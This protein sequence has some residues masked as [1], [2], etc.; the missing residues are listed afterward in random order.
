MTARQ[1]SAFVGQITFQDLSVPKAR[2]SSS[3][4]RVSSGRSCQASRAG[5]R[6]DRE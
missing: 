1:I 4:E 2:H 6:G 3:L 5:Y